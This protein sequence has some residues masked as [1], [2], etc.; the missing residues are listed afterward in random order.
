MDGIGWTASAMRTARA[1]LEI[2]AQ[3]LANASTDGF[4]KSIVNVSL[5]ARGLAVRRTSSTE[6]GALRHTGRPLDLAIVGQGS[7]VVGGK[8][9]RNGAFVRDTHGF[10]ADDRGARVQG[11]H[12]FVRVAPDGTLLDRIPLPYRAQI[13]SGALES[14]NVN[15]VGE[16]VDVLDAQR[17]F[18]TSQKALGAIDETRAKAVNELARL[19]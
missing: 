13:V 2:A 10:L 6:Q 11:A 14:P 17:A 5:N 9:T 7:F 8:P 15:A 18:E 16:M 1:R 4:R 12:G 19:R 3:N